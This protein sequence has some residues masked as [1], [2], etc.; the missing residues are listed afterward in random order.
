M[1]PIK[2]RIDKKDVRFKG[3]VIFHTKK[4]GRVS[5]ESKDLG[6]RACVIFFEK[7]KEFDD[8]YIIEVDEILNIGVKNMAR[9]SSAIYLNNKYV[10]KECFVCILDP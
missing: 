9:Y 2:I 4:N 6:A 5:L 10:G 8:Y 7:Y 1:K 3:K